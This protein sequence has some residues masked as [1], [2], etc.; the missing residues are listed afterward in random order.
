MNL[1]EN[2]SFMK[3]GI[4]EKKFNIIAYNYYWDLKDATW[5]ISM[6][7]PNEPFK[8]ILVVKTPNG[9]TPIYKLDGIIYETYGEVRAETV[10]AAEKNLQLAVALYDAAV[11]AAPF[12]PEEWKLAENDPA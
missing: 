7:I 8:E 11:N 2:I 10:K 9:S 1:D 12:C 5:R 4:D 3:F 6:S